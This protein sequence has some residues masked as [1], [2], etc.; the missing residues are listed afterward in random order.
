MIR[1]TIIGKLNLYQSIKNQKDKMKG[2]G[3]S[4]MEEEFFA[5]KLR[6]GKILDHFESG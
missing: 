1:V 2:K 4:K 6:R 5:K 3:S